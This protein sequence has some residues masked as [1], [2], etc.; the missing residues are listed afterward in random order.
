MANK[1]GGAHVDPVLPDH[2]RRL[3]RENALEWRT[4]DDFKTWTDI[5]APER[6]AVRQVGHELLSTLDPSY[7]ARPP[8]R[9]AAL[10]IAGMA[11]EF[12]TEAD[13]AEH[14]RIRSRPVS[15]NSPCPCGSGK[16]FKHCHGR[17]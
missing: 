17:L 13:V 8:E 2:F 14:E 4:T 16:R 5:P 6:A 3:A 15:R 1:D 7:S 12:A 9:S 11:L 10:E